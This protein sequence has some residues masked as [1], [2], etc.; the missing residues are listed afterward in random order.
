MP[1]MDRTGPFGTGPIGRGRGVCQQADD[2]GFAGRGRGRGGRRGGFGNG[3][4]GFR[5]TGSAP[6]QLSSTQEAEQI[7]QQISALQTRL[8]HLRDKSGE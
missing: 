1:S 5:G 8:N 2:G 6:A 3:R 7:E 4:G